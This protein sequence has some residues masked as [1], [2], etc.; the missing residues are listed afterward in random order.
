LAFLCARG[1]S[2]HVHG[3]DLHE[4]L[5]ECDSNYACRSQVAVRVNGICTA[6]APCAH[7]GAGEAATKQQQCRCV[8]HECSPQFSPAHPCTPF[9]STGYPGCNETGKIDGCSGGCI[10][11]RNNSLRVY[12]S[13]DLSSGSWEL[14][15][16]VS[17]WRHESVKCP[18]RAACAQCSC[19]ARPLT[20]ASQPHARCGCTC[21]TGVSYMRL[22]YGCTWLRRFWVAVVNCVDVN[23]QALQAHT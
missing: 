8:C 21:V 6:L 14:E 5:H 22:S 19:S 7:G 9:T 15:Q 12:S 16:M 23:S 3:H 20:H 18:S 17:G 4:R 13:P 11:G 2:D 10:Y 1:G